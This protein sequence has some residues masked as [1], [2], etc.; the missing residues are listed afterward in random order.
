MSDDPQASI[1]RRG[2]T[3]HH[4]D[5]IGSGVIICDGDGLIVDCNRAVTE[6]TGLGRHEVVGKSVTD[7]GWFPATPFFEDGTPIG[8]FGVPALEGLRAGRRL[9]PTVL[10]ANVE[11]QSEPVWFLL[12]AHPLPPDAQGRPAGAVLTI[13]DI[14]AQKRA[15]TLYATV[16]QELHGVLHALPD[17]YFRLDA[18][19][20]VIDFNIGSGFD[21]YVTSDDFIGLRLEEF[22]PAEFGTRMKKALAAAR[23]SRTVQTTEIAFETTSAG[24]AYFE[25]RFVALPD[26][27]AVVI[28]RDVTEQRQ[29]QEEVARSEHL[30]RSFF[31]RATVGIF[32]F[33]TDLRMVECNDAFLAMAGMTREYF[34]GLDLRSLREQRL[35][36]AFE[37]AVRGDEGSYDGPYVP[38]AGG[39]GGTISLRTQPVYDGDGAV[40]GGVAVLARMT[41]RFAADTPAEPE[42]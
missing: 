19:G 25:G 6:I 26:G 16:V 28:V 41:E 7:P 8:N 10:G 42:S 37:A 17:L 3:E 12:S 24:L 9:P 23:L 32:R 34:T 11:G 27:G 18:Q 21:E 1:A 13:T 38:T 20:T 36:P 40:V 22:L 31:E 4:T 29:A 33:D 35:M 5:A 14:T 15:E 30:Y 2:L 39:F